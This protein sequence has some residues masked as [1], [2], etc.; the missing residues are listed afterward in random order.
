MAQKNIRPT[1]LCSLRD[2]I[3][4]KKIWKRTV[5]EDMGNN[6]RRRRL[7]WM[8]VGHVAKMDRQR[9]A[10]LYAYRPWPVCLQAM[11]WSL[12]GKRKRGRPRKNWQETIREDIRCMD[13]T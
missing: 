9:R 5:Q 12:E 11:D 2:R 1:Q 8:G 4:N 3:T 6:I 13:L 10:G 7:R